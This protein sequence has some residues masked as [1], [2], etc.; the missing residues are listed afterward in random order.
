MDPVT[1]AAARKEIQK[2]FEGAGA[3]KGD[4]GDPGP[5]GPQGPKGDTGPIGPAG[6]E[7]LQG[8]KGDTGDPGPEGP[9]GPKGEPG[10]PGGQGAEGPR[11]E[12]GPQGDPGPKGDI[13]PTGMTGA[14]GATGPQ[15]PAGPQG[16]QGLKG[17]PGDPFLIRKIYPTVS[18]MND[19]FATD[20]LPEGALVGIS[21]DTGGADAAH[22][23]TKGADQYYFFFDLGTISGITGPKGEKGDQ[24]PAGADGATGPQGPAGQKGETGPQGPKG[25]KGDQGLPGATVTIEE[26]DDGN[27]HIRKWSDGYI[28]MTGFEE[29]DLP[30]TGWVKQGEIYVIDSFIRARR[31]P[32]QLSQHYTTQTSAVFGEGTRHA[33]GVWLTPTQYISALEGLPG[34]A[35]WR[36]DIPPETV[37]SKLKFC[38][39]VTGRWK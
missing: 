4:K 23:Y 13:G 32:I 1:L 19:G 33:Y 36:G 21:S 6:P 31:Y 17:D 35:I 7:G 12:Q 34:Y 24:G 27:W 29:K 25:D 37:V 28:E 14:D 15:G 10:E 5:Q 26:S 39:F 2:A 18:D 38:S 8:P 9:Q 30:V 22:L 3:I 16:I 20:G 11:G